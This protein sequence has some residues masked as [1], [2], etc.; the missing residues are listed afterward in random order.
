MIQNVSNKLKRPD[1]VNVVLQKLHL[2]LTNDLQQSSSIDFRIKRKAKLVDCL[3][4]RIRSYEGPDKET[5]EI[6]DINFS[7][8]MSHP[9][10]FW[11]TVNE[12]PSPNL[13]A[14]AQ[15]VQKYVRAHGDDA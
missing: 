15:V 13:L 4:E 3:M 9:Q 5:R 2:R 14:E 6:L 7:H 1:E 12:H 10:S 8:W 11:N